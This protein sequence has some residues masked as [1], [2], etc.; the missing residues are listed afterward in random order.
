MLWLKRALET[1]QM[2]LKGSKRG[3]QLVGLKS[4]LTDIFPKLC[5]AFSGMW[6]IAENFIHSRG[7]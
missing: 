5:E 4:R 7:V 6:Q 1:K 2:Q 3:S